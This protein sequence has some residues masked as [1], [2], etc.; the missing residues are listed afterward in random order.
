LNFSENFP[1]A[2]SANTSASQIHLI[3]MGATDVLSR[4]S[5]V[6]TGDDVLKVLL[7]S[8]LRPRP[9]GAYCAFNSFSTMLKRRTV[10][11]PAPIASNCCNTYHFAVAIPA[12]NVTS[13]STAVAARQ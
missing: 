2:C 4:K 12:I 5:G 8:E 7:L 1:Q 11:S 3:N 6:I 10:C 9:A 13:S